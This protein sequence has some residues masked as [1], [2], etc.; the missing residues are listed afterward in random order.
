MSHALKVPPPGFVDLPV[1][2]QI[3]YV[4][5]LWD[6]IAARPDKVPVPTWHTEILDAR[7]A[8]F[9]KDPNEGV[10]WEEFRAELDAESKRR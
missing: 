9:E 10:T 5:A 8:E 1:E 2:E 6:V 3:D 7:M 4:Q